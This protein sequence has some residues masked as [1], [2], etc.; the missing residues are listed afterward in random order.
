MIG[1]ELVWDLGEGVF[2]RCLKD[3]ENLGIGSFDPSRKLLAGRCFPPTQC[4]QPLGKHTQ[5]YSG[6]SPCLS[7][8]L[9]SDS[10]ACS[11]SS[12]NRSISKVRSSVCSS[13]TRSCN[14]KR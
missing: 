14:R 7:S 1:G 2:G 5:I 13:A 4:S 11:A 9:P 8:G 10:S 3:D 6:S 12:S